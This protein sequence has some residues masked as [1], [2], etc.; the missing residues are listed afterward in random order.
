MGVSMNKEK[1]DDGDISYI[2]IDSP[3]SVHSSE[4]EIIAWIE[5]LKTYPDRPEVK[6]EVSRA[7]EMLIL[8]REKR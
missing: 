6:E 7:E 3:V 8:K 5:E 1:N 2:L 4:K